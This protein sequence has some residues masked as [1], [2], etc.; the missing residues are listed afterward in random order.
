MVAAAE[1][2]A[3][4][5][6]GDTPGC[7]PG[8]VIADGIDHQAFQH[9][10]H[11][12]CDFVEQFVEF[13]RFQII[14]DIVVCME[15]A[16]RTLNAGADASGYGKKPVVAGRRLRVRHTVLLVPGTAPAPPS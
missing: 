14:R 1:N 10:M 7:V 5:H 4:I 8:V 6:F 13:A 9:A 2:L 3:Q 16:A 11:F 15:P 12:A